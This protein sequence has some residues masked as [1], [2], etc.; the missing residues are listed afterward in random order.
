[1]LYEVAR[2]SPHFDPEGGYWRGGVW[3]PTAYMSIKSLEKYGFYDLADTLGKR[4][5][6]HQ[7]NTWKQ[8]KPH[9]IWEAYSPTE[10]KPST[11][12]HTEEKSYCKPDF[13]GCV[14]TSYSIHY[15]K[16]YEKIFTN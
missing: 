14:I 13:C 1:M 9:T 7:Y 12:K 6:M 16:L 3:L 10:A 8:Y 15:T 5:V 2:N 11:R 4:I